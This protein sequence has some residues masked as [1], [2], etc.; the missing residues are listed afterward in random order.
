M[1]LGRASLK[2]TYVLLSGTVFQAITVAEAAIGPDCILKYILTSLPLM[3]CWLIFLM[4]SVCWLGVTRL[5]GLQSPS[6]LVDVC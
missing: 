3:S 4:F 1:R 6:V 2:M 5:C